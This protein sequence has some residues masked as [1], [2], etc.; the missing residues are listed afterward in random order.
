[1]IKYLSISCF[2]FLSLPYLL[3]AQSSYEQTLVI[4]FEEKARRNA[5]PIEY[6]Q[7]DKDIYETGE[8]LWFRFTQ[9]DGQLLTP[10]AKDSIL[11]VRL[12]KQV[13]R[14][15]FREEKYPIMGGFSDGMV[16]ISEE[17][18]PVM[19]QLEAYSP[20]GVYEGMES[21]H[22]FK[23]LE[24]R[25]YISPEI[26]VRTITG[27]E[28]TDQGDL[29]LIVSDK[30]A[31]RLSGAEVRATWLD[32]QKKAV[33]QASFRTDGE[34]RLQVPRQRSD[35]QWLD[36]ELVSGNK[37]GFQRLVLNNTDNPHKLTWHAE[38]GRLVHHQETSVMLS[39]TGIG[40]GDQS[41]QGV[42]LKD[43]EIL[44]FITLGSDGLGKLRIKPEKGAVY[45]ILWND[46]PTD[47]VT[48]FDQIEEQGVTIAIRPMAD[49]LMVGIQT[50]WPRQQ[51]LVRIQVR[52]MVYVLEEFMLESNSQIKIPIAH[53]P[54]GIAEVAVFNAAS[55]PLGQRLTWI[56]N[57]GKLH[58]EAAL[59]QKEYGSREK[60]SVTFTVRDS[61]G[62]PQGGVLLGGAVSD[63]LFQIPGYKRNLYTA[64]HILTQV[65][66]QPNLEAL[67][68]A[69]E[70]NDNRK[71]QTILEACAIEQ[72]SW[73]EAQMKDNQSKEHPLPN[74]IRGQIVYKSSKKQDNPQYALMFRGDDEAS[75]EFIPLDGEG[76]FEIDA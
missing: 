25:K 42:L 12:V 57:H 26:I 51:H 68:A 38:S 16:L 72:Y 64:A 35:A 56:E 8:Q 28:G 30:Q 49:T 20:S 17:L 43:G 23:E 61:Q 33:Y 70:A 39:S 65:S 21:Y 58:V 32:L 76:N 9:L 44:T 66:T 41:R 69:P 50:F 29:A 45:G 18:V 73:L 22:A 71:L 4:D 2:F 19:Y 59:N 62:Q 31:N 46:A 53:I 10:H 63:K 24:I 47:T 15:V 40:T 5:R 60:V 34:G 11:Y 27:E 1:M 37:Q 52:G 6:L 36:L 3:Q 75:T 67:L 54:S 55:E 14:K 74:K 48:V 7:T 13:G